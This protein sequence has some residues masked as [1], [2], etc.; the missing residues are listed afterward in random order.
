MKYIISLFLYLFISGL[1]LGSAYNDKKESCGIEYRIEMSNIAESLTWPILFGASFT[2]D[3]EL[4]A[5]DEVR[6]DD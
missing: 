1:L 2:V 4:M 3:Y 5:N 6:C